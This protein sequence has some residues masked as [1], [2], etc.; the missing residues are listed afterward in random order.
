MAD[1]EPPGN[2]FS[3]PQDSCKYCDII[4]F[5]SIAEAETSKHSAASPPMAHLNN[6]RRPKPALRKV[7]KFLNHDLAVFLQRILV[8]SDDIKDQMDF[9]LTRRRDAGGEF[10][11]RNHWRS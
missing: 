2:P 1:T 10:M 6:Q 9:G 3:V 8:A 11:F 7:F 5:G 4:R